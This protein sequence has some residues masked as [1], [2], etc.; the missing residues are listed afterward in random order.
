M[1]VVSKTVCQVK[2]EVCAWS[3]AVAV[4]VLRSV[5]LWGHFNP[6]DSQALLGP[7][8][9]LTVV[10]GLFGCSEPPRP[11]L[12]HLRPR[13]YPIN[14]HV[15][16]LARPHDGHQTINVLK[17]LRHHLILVLRGRLVFRVAARMDDSIHVEVEIVKLIIVGIGCSEIDWYLHSFHH[18]RLLLL[19]MHHNRRILATQP[20][21]KRWNTHVEKL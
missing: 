16:Q 9:L 4:K 12:I 5:F 21:E 6:S 7:K 8:E 11:L 13:S 2:H 1:D 14:G 19:C 10:S 3:D 17:N 18:L 15:E 20:S